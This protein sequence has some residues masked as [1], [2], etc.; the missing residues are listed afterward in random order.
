MKNRVFNSVFKSKMNIIREFTLERYGYVLT[1]DTYMGL[2]RSR[3]N[4]FDRLLCEYTNKKYKPQDPHKLNLHRWSLENREKTKHE[5][6]YP[7]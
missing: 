3:S 1:E 4:I 7:W 5:Y 2:A 6:E